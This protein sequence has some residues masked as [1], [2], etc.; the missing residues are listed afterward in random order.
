MAHFDWKGTFENQLDTNT[1]SFLIVVDVTLYGLTAGLVTVIQSKFP[2]AIAVC[3]SLK[4]LAFV[5]RVL[6]TMFLAWRAIPPLMFCG[7]TAGC[8]LAPVPNQYADASID[9]VVFRL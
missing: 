3:A 8:L 5:L 1:D 4:Y 9:T 6:A 7:R 2:P